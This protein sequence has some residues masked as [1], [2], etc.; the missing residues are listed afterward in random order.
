MR[1]ESKDWLL[2]CINDKLRLY[3]AREIWLDEYQLISVKGPKW[4]EGG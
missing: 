1:N 4:L 2:K 3:V